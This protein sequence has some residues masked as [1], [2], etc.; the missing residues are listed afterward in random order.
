MR[1]RFHLSR[2]FWC[3]VAVVAVCLVIN[4]SCSSCCCEAVKKWGDNEVVVC[5]AGI[6]EGNRGFSVTLYVKNID[7]LPEGRYE[8]RP[9]EAW[10]RDPRRVGSDGVE[11]VALTSRLELRDAREVNGWGPW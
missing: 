8:I 11:E 5:G 2:R 1:L 6:G 10:D 4:L 3:A 7:D 9:P